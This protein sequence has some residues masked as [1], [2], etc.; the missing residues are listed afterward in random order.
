[1]LILIFWM[2][3]FFLTGL[4]KAMTARQLKDLERAMAFVKNNGFEAH[5]APA[6]I[7]ANKLLLQ[8]RR[9]E[10]IRAEILELKQSTVA[11]IRSYQKPPLPVHTV[12][13]AT[14]LLLGHKEKE[15]HVSEH[16]IL[17]MICRLVMRPQ[18]KE[19][20]NKFAF[21]TITT[22]CWGENCILQNN[23]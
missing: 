6:M 1:M 17:S 21:W 23:S 15:T 18:L 12:M 14:L 13:T 7:A 19:L 20:Q 2:C 3:G 9:L 5:L 10:R 16:C 4:K 8:L 11:E 22:G